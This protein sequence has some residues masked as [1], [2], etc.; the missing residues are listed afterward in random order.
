MLFTTIAALT[1]LAACNYVISG[2]KLLYPPV[3]LCAVW[4]A[5]L[6][7]VWCSQGFLYPISDQALYFFL[8]GSFAFS[9]GAAVVS[10]FKPATPAK[11]ASRG[12]DQL[13]TYSVL[14]LVIIAPI[15]YM[16]LA[17]AAGGYGAPTFLMSVRMALLDLAESGKDGFFETVGAISILVGLLAFNEREKGK[18]RAT[19]GLTLAFLLNAMTG[20]RAGLVFLALG[21]ICIDWMKTRRF[22]WKLAVPSLLF[23]VVAFGVMAFLLHKGVSGDDS[24]LDG[25][26]AAGKQVVLY[27]GG[28]P[29]GF[30]EIIEHPNL[31]EHNWQVDHFVL[32]IAKKLGADVEIPSQHSE[33]LA[34]G[35]GD[36]IGNVYTMYFGYMDWGIAGMMLLVFIAGLIITLVFR[37]ALFNPGTPVLV[38]AILF[39]QTVL[40]VFSE[41]FYRGVGTTLRIFLFAWVI[42][43]APAWFAAYRRM[44]ASATQA[45]I[46]ASSLSS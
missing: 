29:V 39:T 16:R 33:F 40:S 20:G 45:Q 43:N 30:G 44:L 42:Y 22:R 4:I 12:T 24:V 1:L 34:L 25:V 13:V 14:L 7:M 18:W 35:P 37:C 32:Q 9:L 6:F 15:F 26:A 5:D 17:S 3:V 28:G 31:V 19:I 2:F 10:R 36:L 11:P 21:C 46:N 41:N 8:L 23:F 27:T 38:Y